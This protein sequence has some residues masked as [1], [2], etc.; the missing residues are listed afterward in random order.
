[1]SKTR[2]TDSPRP[3]PRARAIARETVIVVLLA[4][5]L[6]GASIGLLTLQYGGLRF[7]AGDLLTVGLFGVVVA[8]VVRATVRL[9]RRWK[10]AIGRFTAAA[11]LC[12]LA[13]VTGALV[14]LVP[15]T[16]PG[17]LPGSGRCGVQEA[18]AWGQVGGVAAVL[19]FMLAGLALATFR[20][21]GNV[22]RDS[23]EQS[24]VWI[25]A[26]VAAWRRRAGRRAPS[27]PRG[28]QDPKGR[29][30]PRRADAQRAR[31]DRPRART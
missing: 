8:A 9:H 21:V 7:G 17:D 18:A 25:R 1:M 5:V 3:R 6:A 12:A 4:V 28:P 26:A 31:R 14:V 13:G 11:A 23:S 24:V 29:P 19:N 10:A 22:L 27:V 15:A 16:C 20:A 2:T 30:T